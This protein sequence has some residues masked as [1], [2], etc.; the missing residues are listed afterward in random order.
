MVEGKQILEQGDLLQKKSTG[1]LFSYIISV[2]NPFLLFNQDI[3][4]SIIKLFDQQSGNNIC[5]SYSTCSM[6]LQCK[7][8]AVL[9]FVLILVYHSLLLYQRSAMSFDADN[10]IP[11]T[12]LSGKKK[13]M[14]TAVARTFSQKIYSIW[15]LKQSGIYNAYKD[16]R[17]WLKQ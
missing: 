6:H 15:R 8:Q 7:S 5:R 17:H 2:K 9:Q 14:S 4:Q 1:S 12:Q 16:V 11:G 13:M 3:S 10:Q